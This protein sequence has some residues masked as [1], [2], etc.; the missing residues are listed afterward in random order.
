LA[1]VPELVR[2]INTTTDS[3][4]QNFV[5]V[6]STLFFT[7]SNGTSGYELWKSDGTSAGT[8]LVKDIL[9]GIDGSFPRGMT[10]VG[11]TLYFRADN[12]VAGAELWKSDG[13]SAGTVLVKDIN[14]GSGISGAKQLVN[15][16]GTLFFV[17]K[18]DAG[19]YELW[20][21]D[22]TSAGTVLVKDINPGGDASGMRYLT[23]VNGT[24]YFNAFNNVNGSELWKSDGTSA[25][26][27][28]VKDIRSGTYNS[29]PLYLV[30]VGGTLFFSATNGSLNQG[31]ELWKSDGTS[32]GTVLVKDI[33]PGGTGSSL[34]SLIN[35]GG[36]L[37]FRANNGAN[38]SE[39][40]KSDGTSGGTVLV[41]DINSGS[42]NSNPRYFTNVGGVVYFQATTTAAGRELWKSDGT[43]IGTVLVSNINPG[44]GNGYPRQ[45]ANVNGT[46]YFQGNNGTTGYELWQSDGTSA[47]T[48]LV[49]DIS[50][51]AAASYP[52][53]LTNVAGTLFF[54]ATDGTT[55]IELWKVAGT[56]GGGSTLTIN[57]TPAADT[58]TI[59]FSAPSTMSVTLNG[60]TTNYDTSTYGN[61]VVN[62]MGGNDALL[63]YTNSAANTANLTTSGATVS[64]LGF[65]F[66]ASN[67]EYKY[68]FG[69]GLDSATF[70]D[71]SSDDQLFQL[72]AYSLMFDGG[73]TYYNQ[74]IGFGSST[75]NASLGNDF[76]LV[77]GSGSNDTY[78]AS[79][80]SSSMASPGFTL[81]ANGFDNVY[82]FGVGGS[83][84]ANFTG[85]ANNENF[86]GLGG[87][88]F[89][90]VTSSNF[91]QYLIGFSQTTVTAGT[92]TDS[93]VFYDAGGNNTFTA[94]PT[95]AMMV[96]S[97]F[98][99]TATG[100]D[101]V[102]AIA[103]GGGVDTANLDGSSQDDIFSGN[104]FD[105]ALF[106]SGV[107]LLQVFGFR[108]VN[109]NL[110]SGSGSDLAEL[111]DGV[112]ND[113]LSASNSTA[114]ITY[115]A[116]N[117]IRVSAFDFVFAKDQNGGTNTKQVTNPLAF[118]LTFQGT[119]V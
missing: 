32:A 37:Y 50:P 56:S 81:A 79:S 88:G 18:A 14:P 76:L 80:T 115:A 69:D 17:A 101:N 38:G 25:G 64:G 53:Y 7:A 95:S 9:P 63:L 109:A 110:S 93:A 85:S 83:D 112:G 30:N 55:S 44:S 92:G 58:L 11:G 4:P 40:W 71:T 105:A 41:K 16:A 61:V 23:N 54:A 75:A 65:T 68:I 86:Y 70:T 114:E 106:R 107:Y 96:G 77:Y 104:A 89:E 27:V 103:S 116:G 94:S 108:Q 19:D 91:L 21:S 36:T 35:V 22:G 26:T 15:V 66:S 3:R 102:Y 33:F 28:M 31:Y 59:Q 6:G 24:L 43:S 117:K 60:T 2:D 73:L 87:Y 82:A 42:A 97:G 111:I 13:T 78:T 84:T 39:L 62:A 98:S 20:K 10:N 5:S 72:P 8:V 46:L 118:Q 57:G 100:F 99:D 29:S 49:K 74:V 67:V 47:G 119:W 12:G 90:V 52:Q 51:G 48:V 1:G 34:Q 113:V 45:L